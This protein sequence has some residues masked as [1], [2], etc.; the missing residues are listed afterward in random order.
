MEFAKH[1]KALNTKKAYD[2]AWRSFKAWCES[3][4]LE[5]MP[6]ESRTLGLWVTALLSAG[7]NPR[8]VYVKVAGVSAMHK[9]NG[10]PTPFNSEVGSIIAGARR[11]LE[12]KSKAKV[13]LTPGQLRKIS[14]LLA[15]DAQ[16]RRNRAILVFGFASSMRRSEMVAL[17]LDDVTFVPRK[18]VRIRIRR[19]KTDQ[20]G[21]GREVGIGFGAQ[22]ETCPVRTLKEWLRVRGSEPGPVFCRIHPRTKKPYLHALN[23]DTISR[24]VKRA[25]GLIG[26]EPKTF[27][28]HS[29]RAGC[30]TA[31]FQAGAAVVAIMRRT[32]HRSVETLQRY[33]RPATVFET[34]PLAGV[35]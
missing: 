30:V 11:L 16:G 3:V 29:L 13:A 34:D 33:Y 19:S 10:F 25:A 27:G 18:G 5:S 12:Y 23:A 28:A 32:G 35:L 24:V 4:H 7:M 8:S 2:Q 6:A 22:P 31:A 26:L 1:D 21:E 17:Q 14:P 15:N 9:T 20:V